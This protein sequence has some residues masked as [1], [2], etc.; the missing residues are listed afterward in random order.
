MTDLVQPKKL[1]CVFAHPDDEAFGPGGSIIH[2]AKTCDVRIICV[3]DGGAGRSS[4]PKL[5]DNLAS[6]RKSEMKESC[7]ILGVKSIT[8][9]DF[10]DGELDNNNYHLVADRIKIE[11][12][13][14]SPD[15][16]LTINIDGCSGH[17]DHIAV[18]M[19]TS[20]LFE[21][22]SYAKQ[23]LYFCEKREIKE[24]LKDSYFV[25]FP[26]G[27]RGDEV[28]LVLDV[29]PYHEAQVQAMQKHVSQKEDCDWIL[30]EFGEHLNTE[31]FRI[32]QK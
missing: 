1:V 8:F 12:D 3:T 9:L 5:A 30:R 24:V 28:D 25:Y 2:F 22:L 31:Y 16:L 29:S 13:K 21:K 6:V 23:L 27:C 20:Y 14:L 18:A 26:Q 17:L 4:D 10:A 32:L 11:L 15:T 19:I 7:K